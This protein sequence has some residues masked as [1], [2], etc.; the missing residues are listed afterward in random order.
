MAEAAEGLDVDE[1]RMRENIDATSGV[2]FAESAAMLLGAKL[3]RDAAHKLIDEAVRQSEVEG[4]RLAEVLG[5]MPEVSARARQ[6]AYCAISNRPRN[7]S[8]WRTNCVSACSPVRGRFE[9]EELGSMPFADRLTRRE[10]STGSKATPAGRCSS[11]R[12]R[13]DATT[14]SGRSRCPTCCSIFRCCATTRA[15]TARPTR[16]TPNT[17]SSS[18][19]ATCSGSPTR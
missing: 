12:T 2:V 3:G 14:A 16:R 17:R 10:S 8:A 4:R 18:S 13:S 7:I 15:G 5:E 1:E 11:F 19:V 9:N 6:Q